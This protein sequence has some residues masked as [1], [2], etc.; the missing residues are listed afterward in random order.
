[1]ANVLE[2]RLGRKTL[3]GT[4]PNVPFIVRALERCEDSMSCT[5][6]FLRVLAANRA[7]HEAINGIDGVLIKQDTRNLKELAKFGLVQIIGGGD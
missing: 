4:K 2:I 3:I 1:M 7:D 5:N 6:T